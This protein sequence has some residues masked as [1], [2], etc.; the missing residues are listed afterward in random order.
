MG[1]KAQMTRG[2]S[3][4]AAPALVGSD[5][6]PAQGKVDQAIE[7][8]EIAA[9]DPVNKLAEIAR[10]DVDKYKS[11]RLLILIS[12]MIAATMLLQNVGLAQANRGDRGGERVGGGG[13]REN[14]GGS[15]QA[16]NRSE[17]ARPA[18]VVRNGVGALNQP[19]RPAVAR[20]QPTFVRNNFSSEHLGTS[21][22]TQGG[23]TNRTT[24]NFPRNLPQ[25]A[26]IGTSAISRSVTAYRPTQRIN[27]NSAILHN[28]Q[29]SGSPIARSSSA[30]AARSDMAMAPTRIVVPMRTDSAAWVTA[31]AA[32]DWVA[33]AS[34]VMGSAGMDW[35][36]A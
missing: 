10:K 6:R 3:K 14:Q 20:T 33:T 23:S 19:N 9:Q 25:N 4:Q 22:A 7:K 15:S 12:T 26:G 24:A 31:M 27:T 34:E 28:Q 32:M 17:A 5:K 35:D 29:L 8:A 2:K 36:M 11:P 18:G 16:Q 30:A 21:A 1:A 13:G